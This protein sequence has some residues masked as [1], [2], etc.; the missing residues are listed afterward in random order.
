MWS[1]IHCIGIT[2]KDANSSLKYRSLITQKYRITIDPS[3]AQEPVFLISTPM[4]SVCSQD[5]DPSMPEFT[6]FKSQNQRQCDLVQSWHLRCPAWCDRGRAMTALPGS[7]NII[8]LCHTPV[9]VCVHSST[10]P[11]F[12][13]SPAASPALSFPPSGSVYWILEPHLSSSAPTPAYHECA[14]DSSGLA[15]PGLL[16][17]FPSSPG[18]NWHKW[19][20]DRN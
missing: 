10:R 14:V 13:P 18:L 19:L 11:F 17:D 3:G 20:S 4:I 9:W 8:H 1:K 12:S 16:E 5:W 2:F 7:R 6:A 15:S